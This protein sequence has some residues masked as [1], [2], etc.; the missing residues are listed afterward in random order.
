MKLYVARS[1]QG[2]L[3]WFKDKPVWNKRQKCW[4]GLR[5]A[6]IYVLDDE[7]DGVTFNN[8]PQTAELKLV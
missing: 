1:A 4:Q 6:T 7:F 8:S 2:D 3:Q 5:I